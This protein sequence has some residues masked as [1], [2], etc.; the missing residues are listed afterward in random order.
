[1]L[2]SNH[3]KTK[4]ASS[5]KDKTIENWLKKNVHK[6]DKCLIKKLGADY[7]L[8]IINI[9]EDELFETVYNDSKDESKRLILFRLN[10][11]Y[12]FVSNP[13]RL[14]KNKKRS[15]AFCMRCCTF[16]TGIS[17]H[18]RQCLNCC[19]FC[20]TASIHVGESIVSCLKCKIEF[21]S[22]D[23]F[24][25]HRN[26][27]CKKIFH[28]KKCLIK[29]NTLAVHQ[30]HECHTFYCY[31]C[32]TKYREG[33]EHVCFIKPI[34]PKKHGEYFLI[35]YDIEAFVYRTKF[36]PNLLVSQIVCE[37][38][39]DADLVHCD[40]C[41]TH[42]RYFD[43]EESLID[44]FID[45]TISVSKKSSSKRRIYLL[46]HG[47]SNFDV[48]IIYEKLLERSNLITKAPIKVGRKILSMGIG[49]NVTFLD[50][51]KFLPRLDI[52]RLPRA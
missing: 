34:K 31:K 20:M 5:I 26:F 48:I 14:V 35:F 41:G 27:I 25:K 6:S 37:T 40:S 32:Q 28:C 21:P 50:T 17:S 43:K 30:K 9:R 24:E 49:R 42:T 13:N 45:Y 16:R 8:V 11:F 19:K 23:C 44:D 51:L 47:S 22:L 52:S 3:L 36:V 7:C 10:G 4:N 39:E 46:A 33:K 18:Y 15:E 2:G 38:C 29:V 1:M 12:Y